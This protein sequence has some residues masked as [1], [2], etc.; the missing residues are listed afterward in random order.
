VAHGWV[1]HTP[2]QEI[3]LPL[4][5]IHMGPHL[6]TNHVTTHPPSDYAQAGKI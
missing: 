2:Y 4:K 3:A 5:A 1:P 6:K